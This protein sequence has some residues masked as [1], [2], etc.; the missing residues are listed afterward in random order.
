M[1]ATL[2]IGVDCATTPKN[3][4][5]AAG[6]LDGK[7][8]EL[9]ITH[10]ERYKTWDDIEKTVVEWI[11]GA[12][13][14]LLAIDAPL[15]WPRPLGDALV[16]CECD[17]N[18]LI[19]REHMAG[20]VL[21]PDLDLRA[22]LKDR[23]SELDR[24]FYRK[25][26]QRVYEDVFER[27]KK[28]LGVGEDKIARTAGVALSFLENLRSKMKREILL[29]HAPGDFDGIFAIEVY[30][31]ATL[32]RLERPDIPHAGYK[33]R[34][35]T[36]NRE[37]IVKGLQKNGEKEMTL[38]GCIEKKMLDNDDILD[39]AVC[40]LSAADFVRGNV[41]LPKNANERELAKKEGWIWVRER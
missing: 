26:E 30:P 32:K 28:P 29:A 39:A 9:V 37:N 23:K 12:E 34:K 33:G 40:V 15:G 6:H 25:T 21:N 17:G 41:D 4:G 1:S 31:A 36:V 38:C 27:H 16:K 3:V 2:L 13:N 5:L 14:C 7:E 10:T 19:K 22:P 8:Q 11:G 20:D 24:M 35:G 18:A